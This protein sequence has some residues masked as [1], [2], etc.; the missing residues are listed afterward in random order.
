MTVTK[1]I[2]SM[3]F[4]ET[5]GAMFRL[6]W[7]IF[8]PIILL[9]IIVDVFSLGFGLLAGLFVGPMLV[10]TSNAILGKRVRALES[11]RKGIFSISFLKIAVV[12]IGYIIFI[13]ILVITGFYIMLYSRVN[14]TETVMFFFFY[15]ILFL[16]F[17]LNPIWIF[18][19][20]VMLLEKKVC[21]PL[22]KD[23]SKF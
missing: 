23:L 3:G 21:A 22:S 14:A 20:M 13:I 19:P 16:Y 7:K 1:Y 18:I 11:I 5:I 12:S 4:W 8:I 2:R 9:N 15:T 6:Y 10:M 17:F